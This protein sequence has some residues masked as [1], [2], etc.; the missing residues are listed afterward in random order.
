VAYVNDNKRR[1]PQ[2]IA[3]FT[4]ALRLLP[5]NTSACHGRGIAYSELGQFEEALADFTS[6]IEHAAQQPDL[7][8]SYQ[9]TLFYERA[10]V[11]ARRGEHDRAI[12]DC[13][14]AIERN[15][16][17][18]K[19]YIVRGAAYLN[20]RQYDKAIADYS[21]ARLATHASDRHS[22]GLI[23]VDFLAR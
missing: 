12:S 13:T 11:Y 6:G 3:D 5:G 18:L 14:V 20:T 8:P 22:A 16:R 19:A 7:D 4:E 1:Y 23:S 21:S 10:V 17:Y 15:S 9:G 2:A